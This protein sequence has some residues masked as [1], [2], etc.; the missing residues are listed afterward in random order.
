MHDWF[1]GSCCFDIAIHKGNQSSNILKI[2]LKIIPAKWNW[3][4]SAIQRIPEQRFEVSVLHEVWIIKN[5]YGPYHLRKLLYE[6]SIVIFCEDA[7]ELQHIINIYNK[8]FVKFWL[9]IFIDPD[10]II[11][12]VTLMYLD[13]KPAE[14]IQIS[15]TCSIKIKTPLLLPSVQITSA[16]YKWY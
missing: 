5:T 15:W 13:D 16:P 9:P 4:S 10:L 2:I 14:A 11:K 12:K 7:N 8:T 1:T 6:D 3:S